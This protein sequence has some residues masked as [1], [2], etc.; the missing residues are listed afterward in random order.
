MYTAAP[1]PLTAGHIAA[2]ASMWYPALQPANPLAAAAEYM[3]VPV[4][5]YDDTDYVELELPDMADPAVCVTRY[6]LQC[7]SLIVSYLI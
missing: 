2:G 7:S 1:N 6:H 4:Q 3:Y 5:V